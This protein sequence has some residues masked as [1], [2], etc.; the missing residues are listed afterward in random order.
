[1]SSPRQDDIDAIAKA[2]LDQ[3]AAGNVLWRK[4]VLEGPSDSWVTVDGKKVL[5]LCSNNYLNLANNPELKL[6]AIKALAEYGVGSGAV[7]VISGTMKIHVQLEEELARFK[8]AQATITFQ[9]GFA[10]NL[11]VIPTLIGEGDVAVS[12]ELNHGSII[13]G[14]RMSKA[15]R[16]VYGH[17]DM[18]SLKEA[19]EGA[20]SFRR[21]LI[22]T[23][24]V[25]SMD[26][27][28]A[29]IPEIV[30]LA[31]AYAS[32]TYVDDAHGEGVLGDL[33]RGVVNHFRLQGR[34]DVEM[35]TF[36]KAFGCVGG[37]VAGSKVLCDYLF[38]KVRPFL[39]SGSHPPAVAA[40]NLAAVRYVQ[41]HPELFVTLWR[42]TAYF[43]EGLGK[44]GFD[45]GRSQTPITPVIVGDS[46]KAQALAQGLFEEGAFVT[47]IVYPMVTKDRARV[48]TI[49][50]AGHT[51]ADLDFALSKFERVGRKLG[52]V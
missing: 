11:G 44:L 46:G 50:T 17:C 32:I 15:E 9:S 24:A 4:R 27:D 33:G 1:M 51:Q 13:D 31:E 38:N 16:R 25:F 48:R 8:E 10:T 3:M 36:S 21:V 26:G 19:L 18:E 30:K 41:E 22:I 20:S 37:Y 14:I 42:N 35:G 23:D 49:V 5:M 29:P 47:P 28:I 43:K 52:I 39:L 6:E 40:A 45:T 7:R 12:D 34:V 2:E